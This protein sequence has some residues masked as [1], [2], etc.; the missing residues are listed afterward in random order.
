MGWKWELT[1]WCSLFLLARLARGGGTK[2]SRI[3]GFNWVKNVMWQKQK[4]R[5]GRTNKSVHKTVP[6]TSETCYLLLERIELSIV[7][8]RDGAMFVP[9]VG[10]RTTNYAVYNIW[11]GLLVFFLRYIQWRLP[12]YIPACTTQRFGQNSCKCSYKKI[13]SSHILSVFIVKINMSIM[14][15]I[16]CVCI[17]ADCWTMKW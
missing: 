15:I 12:Q 3:G 9:W 17:C 14:L 4:K 10:A 1:N 7:L 13:S 2:T 6:R 11:A 8:D 16:L 5:G